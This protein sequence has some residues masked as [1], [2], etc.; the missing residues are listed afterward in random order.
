MAGKKSR[1][2][3]KVK[4]KILSEVEITEQYVIDDMF[5]SGIRGEEL[6]EFKR[7]RRM[8]EWKKENYV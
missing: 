1:L 5:E 3:S 7:Y 2:K 8:S 4:N 6:E